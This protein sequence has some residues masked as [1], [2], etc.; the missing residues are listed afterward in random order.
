MYYYYNYLL[1]LWMAFKYYIF[2]WY[3]VTGVKCKARTDLVLYN[4]YQSKC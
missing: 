3:T 4:G 1:S 2:D